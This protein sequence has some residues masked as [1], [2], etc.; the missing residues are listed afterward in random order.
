MCRLPLPLRPTRLMPTPGLTERPGT[1]CAA[2]ARSCLRTGHAGCARSYAYRATGG[3]R[4]GEGLG[5]VMGLVGAILLALV[6]A[7]WWW[8]SGRADRQQAAANSEKTASCRGACHT[9]PS[10]PHARSAGPGSQTDG[11][12]G[13]FRRSQPPFRPPRQRRNLHPPA[14]WLLPRGQYP[15]RR[16]QYRL[17]CRCSQNGQHLQRLRAPTRPGAGPKFG[18]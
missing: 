15:N 6:A 10:S 7:G 5:C 1:N 9:Y 17:V 4:S 18:R 12:T 8:F 2:S 14:N 13:P 16:F 11:K 3:T